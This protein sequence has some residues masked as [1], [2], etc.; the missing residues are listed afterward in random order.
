VHR[1]FVDMHLVDSFVWHS[2][3]TL[4]TLFAQRFVGT[5]DERAKALN[6][7][8]AAVD[9]PL[10]VLDDLFVAVPTPAFATALASL[11]RERLDHMRPMLVTSN[12]PPQWA[13]YLDT[14]EVG[15]LDSRWRAS[16]LEVVVSGV[17]LRR[18]A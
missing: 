4:A 16:G 8:Q 5:E 3:A 17:D 15:R 13:V 7:W 9:T 10:L 12:V 18:V 2:Q 1:A 6:V 14:D 11:V